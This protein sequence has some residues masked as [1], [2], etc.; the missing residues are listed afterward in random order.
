MFEHF[1]L[2]DQRAMSEHDGFRTAER[3]GGELEEGEVV[4]G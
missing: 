2:G 3:A 4:E 1:D